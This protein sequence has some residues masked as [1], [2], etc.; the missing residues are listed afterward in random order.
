MSL[1]TKNI[2][3]QITLLRKSQNL[4]QAELGERL[5]VSFQAVSKWERGE[6][7]PDVCLLL[8]LANV[9][10][11]SVDNILTGGKPSIPFKGKVTVSDMKAGID[12]LK[13]AGE[14]LKKD[15][16]IYRYAVESINEKMNTDIEKAFVDDYICECFIAEAI[17]QCLKNGYYIYLT[18]INKNFKYDKF[19][20][21][22]LDFAGKYGIK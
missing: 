14:Y 13:K 20:N 3:N 10:E 9:L 1:N 18:D 17:I 7:L 22:V 6:T 21:I 16:I 15:N 4:T 19:R 2:G 8:D 5:N 11:T 12:S